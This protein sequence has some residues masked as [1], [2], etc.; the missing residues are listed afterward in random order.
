MLS[1]QS[2]LHLARLSH[3]APLLPSLQIL[4]FWDLSER[5]EDLRLLVSPSLS[6]LSL[7][8][9]WNTNPGS[10]HV[11]PRALQDILTKTPT[12]TYLE[13]QD[14]DGH[15]LTMVTSESLH[16]M[17]EL[18]VGVQRSHRLDVF[19]KVP[20]YGFPD[21]NSLRVMS[22]LPALQRLTVDLNF[23]SAPVFHGFRSLTALKFVDFNHNAADFLTMCS[24]PYLR[25]LDLN[26]WRGE[27]SAG[28]QTTCSAIARRVPE[29]RSLT[30]N[31]EA[32]LD[33]T[34]WT[35]EHTLEAFSPLFGLRHLSHVRIFAMK[36]TFQLSDYV[37]A[38]FAEAW[39][40]LVRLDICC[41]PFSLDDFEIPGLP[42]A[43]GLGFPA[44]A[45]PVPPPPVPELQLVTLRALAAFA[46]HCPGLRTLR[47]PHLYAAAPGDDLPS[48]RRPNHPLRELSICRGSVA[49]DAHIKDLARAV[50]SMFPHIDVRGS[51]KKS[52]CFQTP[53]SNSTSGWRGV[54]LAV[55]DCSR[56]RILP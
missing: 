29:L 46:Q 56:E 25:K 52:S 43:V 30:F 9:T 18:V 40:A 32:G 34:D 41:H 13:L 20:N 3:G 2:W 36:G 27:L 5:C 26:F 17:K 1:E 8:C 33:D 24:S 16:R 45:A 49:D 23:G 15:L 48:A 35:P 4:H 38:T 22:T 6:E 21:V 19:R 50:E 39:P 54:L 51:L 44:L 28:L 31:F 42:P 11:F 47:L 10:E 53:R 7:Q 37:L 14:F 55:E 12:I